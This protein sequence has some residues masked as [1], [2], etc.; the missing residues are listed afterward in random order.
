[1]KRDVLGSEQ[2]A[3]SPDPIK[4]YFAGVLPRKMQLELDYRRCRTPASDLALALL[5]LPAL[6]FPRLRPRIV[7][8]LVDEHVA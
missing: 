7:S 1:M 8:W 4:T 3:R 5:T 2:L 6:L